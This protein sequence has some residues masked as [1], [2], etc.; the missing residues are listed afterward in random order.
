M[1]EKETQNLDVTE[2]PKR[3]ETVTALFDH[4]A[5]QTG[6]LAFKKG[7]IIVI[8]EK[9]DDGLWLGELYGKKGM[10]PSNFFKRR[11]E[12][13]KICEFFQKNSSD[14]IDVLARLL[15]DHKNIIISNPDENLQE[16]KFCLTMKAIIL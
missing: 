15:I 7:D 12:K 1:I 14:G 16:I 11:D 4:G 8:L 2:E 6:H 3:I 5:E 10:V 9:S 13:S